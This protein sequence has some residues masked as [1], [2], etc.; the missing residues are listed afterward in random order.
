MLNSFNRHRLSLAASALARLA[1]GA[2]IVALPLRYRFVLAARPVL[3]VYGDYTDILLFWSDIFLL[4][5]LGLWLLSLALQPRSVSFGPGFLRWPLAALVGLSGVTAFFSVDPL[6]SF[7]HFVRLLLLAGLALYVANEVE[8]VGPWI[9]PAAVMIVTQSVVG[10]V[11]VLSQRSV[12]LSALGE[13]AL[14][15]QMKG[16]SV[17][18]AGEQRFLRAYGLTDH[19]NLLGGCLAFALVLILAWHGSTTSR[20]RASW[21]GV[22]ALGALALYLTFSRSAWLALGAGAL[23]SAALVVFDR[24]PRLLLDW[25]Y[26]AGAALLIL[27]P[28]VWW[29]APYLGMRLDTQSTLL[30]QAPVSERAFLINATTQVFMQHPL[31]GVG[32]GALPLALRAAFPDFPLNYQPAHFAL[33]EAAAETGLPGAMA[34][35]IALIAPWLA[36]MW[37]W[38]RGPGRALS[39]ALIAASGAL[40]AV[41]LVG[42]FDYYTWL[43]APGRLWQW[44]VWGLWAGSYQSAQLRSPLP[45]GDREASPE[46]KRSG[47]G[48][49]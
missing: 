35:L 41:T 46:A 36:L 45:A 44:L 10:I 17:V 8:S 29:T 38:R 16:I 40:V 30:N 39:P 15:P 22:F 2:M 12:G 6:L 24:Q 32:V 19:P 43:L 42:F 3:P 21:A 47:E 18:F 28:F 9:V 5:A 14:D 13:W 20:R 37:G 49:G 1:L 27:A 4:A 33:L 26:L 34:Y 25:L 11:Q 48:P 31:T 23:A 7:H